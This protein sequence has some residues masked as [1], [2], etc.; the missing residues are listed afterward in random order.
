[1]NDIKLVVGGSLL[2]DAS[3]FL[4]AWH[5]AERGEIA[6]NRIIAFESW[7]ALAKLLTGERY[8]LLQHVHAHPE[9]SISAIARSLGRQYR[10]V[11]DDVTALEAAG[12]LSR[13]SGE[14][15][16]TADHLTADI[17]LSPQ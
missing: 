8:R 1:M 9:P 11:H 15:H 3:G 10:R 16:A 7:D 5:D 2:D 17:R 6:Q 12:L 4:K 14:I 13:R